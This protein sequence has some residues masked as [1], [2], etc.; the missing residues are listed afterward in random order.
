MKATL[1]PT[2][3]EQGKALVTISGI[4]AKYGNATFNARYDIYGE[5]HTISSVEGS[6]I[7]P[8]EE[9]NT[10]TIQFELYH[11][12]AAQRLINKSTS[13]ITRYDENLKRSKRPSLIVDEEEPA[14]KRKSFWNMFR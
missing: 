1:T 5:D 11:L 2:Y 13:F 4:C 10:A 6:F 3:N 7:F 14:E 12:N 9:N 8:A